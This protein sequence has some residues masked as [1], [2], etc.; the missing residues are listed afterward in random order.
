MAGSAGLVYRAFTWGTFCE[1]NSIIIRPVAVFCLSRRLGH[2][3]ESSRTRALI[4]PMRWLLTLP[5]KA[6]VKAPAPVEIDD[7]CWH[8]HL[9]VRQLRHGHRLRAAWRAQ[10]PARTPAVT[11]SPNS[12]GTYFGVGSNQFSARLVPRLGG[13]AG[14]RRINLYVRVQL[15]DSVHAE[16]RL[17]EL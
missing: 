6:A 17:S 15:A 5:Y 4:R 13:A 1:K 8:R 10:H 16:Q 12:N 3:D 9:R 2:A 7:L 14:S 11:P